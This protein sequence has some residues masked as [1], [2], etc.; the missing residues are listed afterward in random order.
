MRH[1]ERHEYDTVAGAVL[2]TLLMPFL[3]A[4]VGGVWL[5]QAVNWLA[6]DLERHRWSR[7]VSISV[8]A[9]FIAWPGIYYVFWGDTPTPH[10]IL[11]AWVAAW[12]VV[13][14]RVLKR[15]H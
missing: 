15:W 12:S 11:Y 9:F 14:W 2:L 13:G 10:G 3:L 1:I 5:W 8:L 7:R 4:V 6:D